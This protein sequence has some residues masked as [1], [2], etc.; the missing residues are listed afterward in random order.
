MPDLPIAT[1]CLVGMVLGTGKRASPIKASPAGSYATLTADTQTLHPK[2]T[3]CP[4]PALKSAVVDNFVGFVTSFGLF[5]VAY[6]IFC[7]Y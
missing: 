7:L 5:G 6:V 2:R 4:V 1:C 3:A